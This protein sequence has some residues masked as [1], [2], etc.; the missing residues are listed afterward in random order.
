MH[1]ARP[2]R[3]CRE[4]ECGRGRA[5]RERRGR[6][7]GQFLGNERERVSGRFARLRAQVSAQVFCVGAC[8]RACVRVQRE[9]ERALPATPQ[10]GASLAIPVHVYGPETHIT[11]IVPMAL[12]Y[13]DPAFKYEAKSL[14]AD[15]KARELLSTHEWR[16][17][18]SAHA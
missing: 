4:L 13:I 1:H 12:A 5:V 17:R 6:G 10:A 7:R 16:V 8:V 15:G 2:P 18:T 9:R 3:H 14:V 11:A